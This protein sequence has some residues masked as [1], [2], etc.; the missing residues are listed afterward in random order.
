MLFTVQNKIMSYDFQVW[1]IVSSNVVRFSI[2]LFTFGP[3]SCKVND[4]E[5]S[6]NL[7]SMNLKYCR[8]CLICQSS[9][10]MPQHKK[11]PVSR[12]NFIFNFYSTS[13]FFHILVIWYFGFCICFLKLTFRFSGQYA[14]FLLLDFLFT[15]SAKLRGKNDLDILDKFSG[16]I[17]M[18]FEEVNLNW[19]ERKSMWSILPNKIN[20]TA[21]SS[22]IDVLKMW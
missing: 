14:E 5:K 17:A 6:W 11:W 2:L 4:F 15:V 3:L 12:N 9:I 16:W 18:K 22:N 19:L 7:I 8:L 21:F 13:L 20:D 1:R 10:W